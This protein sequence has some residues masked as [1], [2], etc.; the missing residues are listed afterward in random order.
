[1]STEVRIEEDIVTNNV[2]IWD[3]AGANINHLMK[4]TPMLL[5]KFDSLMVR[6]Y[7]P[8]VVTSIVTK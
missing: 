3:C 4:Y 1:M 7:D 5:K 2:V 8:A 6:N